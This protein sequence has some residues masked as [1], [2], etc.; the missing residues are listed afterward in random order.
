MPFSGIEVEYVRGLIRKFGLRPPSPDIESWPWPVKIHT[1]G[2][3]ELELQGKTAAFSAKAPRKVLALLKGLICL[4]GRDVPHYQLIDAL[5]PDEEGD[6]ARAAFGVA[7]HRLRKLLGRNEA[8]ELKESHVRLNPD[9]VWVDAFAF[10]RL[11]SEG[12]GEAN[13]EANASVGRALSL[14]KGSLLPSDSEQPW[15]SAM[16]ERLR[17]KFIHHVGQAGAQLEHDREWQHAIGLYLR[18]L[19]ADGLTE[20]FYRGLMRCH[21]CMGR[22]AEALSVY[23]RMRQTLSV[24]L[25]IKPSP[26]SE[27]LHASLLGSS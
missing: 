12:L 10:E 13:G 8:I 9:I 4:G 26:E 22:P 5:W 1:V 27:T 23:R 16:R 11:A 14:Y 2:R 25:G 6:A 15:S 20:S 19:D 3:F 18:G 7:I 17:A 21:H 24:T